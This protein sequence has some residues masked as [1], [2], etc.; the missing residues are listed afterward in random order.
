MPLIRGPPQPYKRNELSAIFGWGRRRNEDEYNEQ[1]YEKNIQGDDEA[2]P[3]CST[4]LAY[5][6][7]IVYNQFHH[8]A[9]CDMCQ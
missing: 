1:T 5:R 9:N 4:V 8:T 2:I 6:V 7:S 3:R